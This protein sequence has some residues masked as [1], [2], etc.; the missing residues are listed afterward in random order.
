MKTALGENREIYS[1]PN[2]DRWLLKRDPATGKVFVR[3][4]ANVLSG[5]KRIEID[6][7]EFSS[8]G[9]QNPEYQALFAADWNACF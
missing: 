9:Q 7:A 8:K 2:E 5:G 4:E 3:H 1:S 6:I